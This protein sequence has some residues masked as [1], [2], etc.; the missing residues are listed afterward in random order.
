MSTVFSLDPTST[1]MATTIAYETGMRPHP[2][3][4]HSYERSK[5][6]KLHNKSGG[7]IQMH[8]KKTFNPMS[9]GGLSITTE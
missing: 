2:A 3:M 1:K 8:I 9:S 7:T 6:Y 5:A 4:S